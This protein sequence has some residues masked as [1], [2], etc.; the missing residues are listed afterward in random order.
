M[1]KFYLK[2]DGEKVTFH[3]LSAF[4]N[5]IEKEI[6][7]DENYRLCGNPDNWIKVGDD[8]E[9]VSAVDKDERQRIITVKENKQKANDLY[10]SIENHFLIEA[11]NRVYNFDI[12]KKL[13]FFAKFMMQADD[14][15]L[16]WDD[17]SNE[18][19]QHNK[20]GTT[21]IIQSADTFLRALFNAKKA[22]KL[23]CESGDYSLTN[24]TAIKAQQDALR[25]GE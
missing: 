21:A 5:A 4:E 22:D 6:T 25:G 19:V 8:F 15:F 20:Q 7:E 12:S 3:S 18:T 24:L 17:F 10:S 9:V 16:D 11:N 1:I 2:T 13:D 14:E 23:A